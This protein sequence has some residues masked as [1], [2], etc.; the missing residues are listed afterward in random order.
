M[1]KNHYVKAMSLAVM[2]ATSF[3]VVACDNDAL[4]GPDYNSG[5]SSAVEQPGPQSSSSEVIESSSS[6]TLVN[7]NSSSSVE[8]CTNITTTKCMTAC[9]A[10]VSPE[11]KDCE[12]GVVFV[13]KDGLWKAKFA[14]DNEAVSKC[15][16]GLSSS[17]LTV[18]SSSSVAQKLSSSS[19][20]ET[21]KHVSDVECEPCPPGEKCVCHPCE[22]NMERESRDCVTGES[23]YCR[24]GEWK[25]PAEM[26]PNGRWTTS[27]NGMETYEPICCTE[28]SFRTCKHISDY[29]GMTEQ[30]NCVGQN[31]LTA[32]DCETEANY[33]CRDNYWQQVACLNIKP[34]ECKPGMGGCGYRLCQPNG[35]REIADCE[36]SVKYYCD[37]EM[38]QVKG[39]TDNKRCAQGE[40][41][42]CEACYK[43]GVF[44]GHY[45]CE[46]GKWRKYGMGDEIC[47]HI[48]DIKCDDKKQGC[49]SCG[50]NQGKIAIDCE[51][52]NE[53]VCDHGFWTLNIKDC[54]NG[55]G[56][57]C[58]IPVCNALAPEC[59][60]SEYELCNKYGIDRYCNDKW[61][62]E[63]CDGSES[64]RD[65]RIV[66]PNGSFRVENYI[67]VNNKWVERF[68]YYE[69][70]EDVDCDRPSLRCQES[71]VI[72]TACENE[73]EP[74]DIDGCVFLC[75]AGQFIYAPAPW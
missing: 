46:G 64:S 16:V 11:M 44:N 28:S 42:Y 53:F 39:N 49:R 36:T 24:D 45:K 40:L 23:L 20:F 48:T 19:S 47:E 69:C 13:C 62:S 71:S 63:P 65:L 37:G 59:G 22:S 9:D 21:C 6:E 18:V 7:G 57:G 73:G 4:I 33:E 56:D 30:G 14:K 27:C 31:G 72:G 61:L 54:E 5:N 34:D 66:G 75:S 32:V 70:G 50:G 2:A 51:T 1:K 3:A 25:T 38:W 55:N 58:A 52:E 8:V 68:K 60:Y 43:E 15:F 35:I 12:T 67:C 26:C 74:S 41:E 10:S 29:D 17:S